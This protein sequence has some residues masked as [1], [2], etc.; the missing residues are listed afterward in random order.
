MSR[1]HPTI[2]LL[3]LLLDEFVYSLTG[4]VRQEYGA[5]VLVWANPD[6]DGLSVSLLDMVEVI[7]SFNVGHQRMGTW[8]RSARSW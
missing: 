7:V 6:D 3:L 1:F 8:P 5:R 2:L 4:E